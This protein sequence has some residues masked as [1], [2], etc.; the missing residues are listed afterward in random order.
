M[1]VVWKLSVMVVIA[2]VLQRGG[3]EMFEAITD[4]DFQGHLAVARWLGLDSDDPEIRMAMQAANACDSSPARPLTLLGPTEVQL[5]CPV[6]EP[7]AT[8][9][10]GLVV[11]A[12]PREPLPA[13]W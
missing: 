1:R 8:P 6:E 11:V 12:N 4:L 3:P 9:T 13:A 10:A 7:E 5:V 2:I